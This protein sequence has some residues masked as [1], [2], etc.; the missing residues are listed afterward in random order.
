MEHLK[1]S[2]PPR[3]RHLT[4]KEKRRLRAAEIRLFAKL[5]ARPAQKGRE[6]NDRRYSEEVERL[7]KR[8]RPEEF[9]ELLRD[10][11]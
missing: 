2:D 1:T 5:Y 8:P 11:E 10:E 3:R 6:P 7:V 9:D 4:L